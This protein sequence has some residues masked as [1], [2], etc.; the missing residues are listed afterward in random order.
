M[1]N[2][3]VSLVVLFSTFSVFAQ[4]DTT[5][6]VSNVEP[7]ADVTILQVFRF[8]EKMNMEKAL[9]YRSCEEGIF[10]SISPD[11]DGKA[12]FLVFD[13]TR[14]NQHYV[15]ASFENKL[16]RGK[17]M[18]DEFLSSVL[19]AYPV[20]VDGFNLM[21]EYLADSFGEIVSFIVEKTGRK[22]LF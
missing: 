20:E 21:P 2:L 14:Y 19:L 12:Y 7:K 11:V 22:N 9:F 3:L 13:S 17:P 8:I 4:N 1:K 10:C 16:T 6:V 15:L 18:F 5:V